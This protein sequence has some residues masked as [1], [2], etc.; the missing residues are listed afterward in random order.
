MKVTGTGLPGV[1][2]VEPPV[3]R[4]PR[5]YFM[6]TWRQSRY[7]DAGISAAFVQDNVSYSMK[8]ALRGLHFQNPHPQAKLIQALQGEIFDVAVDIR[9][10]SPTFGR[11]AGVRLSSDHPRQLY[12]PE[13]FA[14]GFLVLSATALVAYKCS[15][16]Y[17]PQSENAIA[18][19]DPDIGIEWPVSN[20][21]LSAKDS[22]APRLRDTSTP[23]PLYRA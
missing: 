1:L 4:D 2:I 12:I 23:L 5:G 9:K 7:G 10:G 17:D 13:G 15:D 8:N 18:W 22:A 21:V 16:Y 19:N 3:F 14:H 11:W 20:P 6:E